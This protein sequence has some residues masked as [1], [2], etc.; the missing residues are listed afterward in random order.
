MMMKTYYKN[1]LKFKILERIEQ[2][3][4]NVILRK[5]VQ[6]MGGA[7]QISRCFKDLVE[8]GKLVRIGSG[9]YAKSYPSQY[10]STILVRGGADQAFRTALT[11]L[12]ILYEPSRAEQ[13]YNSGKTTQV[14]VKNAVRLKTRCRRTLSYGNNKLFFEGDIN[15]R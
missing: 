11:R 2:I 6:D 13:D 1:S 3:S 5:D 7:R 12:K 15:A 10:V 4:G 8:M 14:P 9:V